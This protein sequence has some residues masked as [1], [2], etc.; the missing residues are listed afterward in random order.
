MM[1]PTELASIV[2]IAVIGYVGK[3]VII[4]LGGNHL[5]VAWELILT[6]AGAVIGL[7]FIW[8]GMKEIAQVVGV[9]F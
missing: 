3:N 8:D 2:G 4:T 7:K 5:A 6:M 1:L 9:M